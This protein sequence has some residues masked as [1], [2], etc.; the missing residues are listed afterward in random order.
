MIGK[1]FFRRIVYALYPESRKISLARSTDDPAILAILS[2]YEIEMV[3]YE[4]AHNSS[5][6][7]ETL[8][9]MENDSYHPVRRGICF[10]PSTPLEVRVR[11]VPILDFNAKEDMAICG[12]DYPREML[13]VLAQ[14]QDERIKSLAV[15]RL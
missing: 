5:A 6:S 7:P 15:R 8:A 10:N 3:R 4:V 14:D 1:R 11:L 2:K 12:E 9:A 13:E